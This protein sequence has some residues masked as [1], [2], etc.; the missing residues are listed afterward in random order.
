MVERPLS[1]REVP[2]SMPA[3]ST[4]CT[5]NLASRYRLSK[6]PILDIGCLLLWQ[7]KLGPVVQLVRAHV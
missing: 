3:F 2:G 6:D 5:I 4:C 7:I 1:M